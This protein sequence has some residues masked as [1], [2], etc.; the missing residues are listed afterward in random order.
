[1]YDLRHLIAVAV[2]MTHN[3]N[4]YHYAHCTNNHVFW[5]NICG[6]SNLFLSDWEYFSER[7]YLACLLWIHSLQE[8]KAALLVSYF[9]IITDLGEG[10]TS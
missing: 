3:T 9:L 10:A 1:M 5:T 8:E 7:L 2:S 6:F 4:K